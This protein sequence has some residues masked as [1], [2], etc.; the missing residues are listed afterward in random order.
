MGIVKN[1]L[2]GGNMYLYKITNKINQKVYIGITNDYKR[3]WANH[4]LENSVISKAI[5]KYGKENFNFEILFKN[6][7]LEE[8]DN[9][10]KEQIKIYDCLV[11]KGYNVDKGGRYNGGEGKAL[12]GEK[13]GNSLLTVEEVRYIKNNR[14]LP[15][16]VLYDLFSDK[17]SYETFKKVYKNKTYLNIKPTVE[18]YPNNI[19]FSSQFSSKAKLDYREICELRKKYF[20]GIYWKEAY[21][22]FKELYPN[23]LVFW[24][25]YTGKQYSLVM[26]EVFTK[27]RKDYHSGLG[28]QGS[29]NSRAKLTETDVKNI[30][31][32]HQEG[33]TNSDIYVLYPQVSKTSI[34]DIINNKTWKNIL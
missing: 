8:I 33:K 1:D 28:S 14:N 31:K 25:I 12:Q 10:E 23:E 5:Q 29:R 22:P 16:Y 2:R 11:P 7:S 21:K 24:K 17:I 13:N 18:E 26:P 3:R 6:V 20:E 9:L 32:L 15:M 30:R 34:R 4:G 27:E 19:Q